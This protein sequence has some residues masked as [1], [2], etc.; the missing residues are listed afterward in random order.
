MSELLVVRSKLKD[1][2]KGMNVASD[3]ADSLS[4]EVEDMVKRACKRASDNGRKT[5]QGRDL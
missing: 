5:V 3:F 1:V 2:A 4:K